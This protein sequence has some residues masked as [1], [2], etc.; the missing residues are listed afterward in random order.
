MDN[1]GNSTVSSGI[2]NQ[3][4]I[5]S[6]PKPHIQ[7]LPS[8][9][10]CYNPVRHR[11]RRVSPLTPPGR[12]LPPASGVHGVGK[13]SQFSWIMGEQLHK[14]RDALLDLVYHYISHRVRQAGDDPKRV[15]IGDL[16]ILTPKTTPPKNH[17]AWHWA[18]HQ[19][20]TTCGGCDVTCSHADHSGHA[21]KT[22]IWT[23]APAHGSRLSHGRSRGYLL[24]GPAGVRPQLFTRKRRRTATRSVNLEAS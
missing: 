13:H 16:I 14:R 9:A 21:T 12:A 7:S 19:H 15:N 22:G 24:P 5:L 11:P 18:S 2:T 23:E 8:L 1:D 4:Q 3:K 10:R 20:N 6:P 17:D